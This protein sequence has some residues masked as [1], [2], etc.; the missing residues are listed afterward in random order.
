MHALIAI[1][2]AISILELLIWVPSIWEMRKLL[3]SICIILLSLVSLAI[4]QTQA[5][6]ITGLIFFFSLYRLVNLFRL[7]KN[8]I[9]FNHLYRSSRN[10]SISLIAVQM[11]LVGVL[12]ISNNYSLSRSIWLIGLSLTQL[13]VGLVFMASTARHLK[14]TKP[15]AL[16]KAYMD[17]ELPTVTVAI[18]AR[19]E[20]DN[21]SQCLESLIQSNY[22]KLEILVLDDCSQ[23]RRTPEIIRNFALSGVRFI[24]GQVPP[25]KWLAKNYAYKQ[26]VDESSG[27]LLLFCGVDTRFE[28]RTIKQLVE[29]LLQKNKNMISLI[30]HNELDKFSFWN[31]LVQ[32]SRYAWEL[33]LPRHWFRRP[34]VLSTCW[35]IKRE[36]LLASGG[37]EAVAS[38]ISP[39]SYFARQSIAT[40]DGY[41]F[42]QASGDVTVVCVKSIEDQQ[43]TVIRTR[44]PQLH[45]RP[46]L[47][48]IVTIAEF[49]TIIAPL[50]VLILSLIKSSYFAATVSLIAVGLQ[51]G[52]YGKLV[53]LTY[54]RNILLGYL[55]LPVAA[56]YD[57]FLLNYSMFRYEFSEVIWKDRNIC[58][59]VMNTKDR[60]YKS[61]SL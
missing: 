16:T 48:A 57:L 45:R 21:L 26:L 37:F 30:P 50:L 53:R 11:S 5:V 9:H 7:L 25:E 15:L 55:V 39:E 27:E 12:V 34:P 28:P 22:P 54:R 19:N 1:L 32:P 14:T 58:I 46:E 10:T 20:T 31:L 3:A 41:S 40:N 13:T 56:M 35:I 18:P 24:S 49:T 4:L 2:I 51:Y 42:M 29:L 43:A 38:S 60:S 44:Y 23:D 17:K 36:L 6:V 47:A 52:A 61:R 8:R 33:S 59:P